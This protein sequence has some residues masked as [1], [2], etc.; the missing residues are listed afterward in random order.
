VQR[1]NQHIF[2]VGEVARRLRVSQQHVINQ[3]ECGQ[4]EAIDVSGR[5]KRSLWRIPREA[6][7]RYKVRNSSMTTAGGAK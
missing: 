5:G 1:Q 3:I 6:F 7:E 2:T 4:L